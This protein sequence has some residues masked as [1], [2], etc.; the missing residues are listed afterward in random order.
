[1]HI[2]VKFALILVFGLLPVGT[3]TLRLLFKKTIVWRIALLVFNY[4]VISGFFAFT[5]GILG[6]KS[7]YW[8]V[9]VITL[10]LL[11]S[12][13]MIVHFVQKPI[14]HLTDGLVKLSAGNLKIKIDEGHLDRQDEVGDMSR[15]TMELSS[16]ISSIIKS[17][18]DCSNQVNDLSSLL[19]QESKGLTDQTNSQSGAAE[20]ISASMEEIAANIENN[21]D[22]A[23]KTSKIANSAFEQM[24]T[25]NKSMIETMSILT[26]ISDKIGI[27]SDIA[28]QTNI[29]ALNAAVESARAGE[30]GKG[31]AVV[32]A[33]V[34]KLAERSNEAA[35]EILNLAEQSS[36]LADKSGTEIEKVLPDIKQTSFMIDEITA[37]TMEQNSGA[38]QINQALISFSHNTQN[39]ARIAESLNSKASSL[40]EVASNLASQI[41]YFNMD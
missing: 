33:E 8:V 22:N 34:R 13:I 17:I 40:S 16:K 1:M 12:N 11:T 6:L 4:S 7:L 39:N 19:N 41:S 28:S 14:Q 23:K 5:V 9:P 21:T 32:A 37:A 10:I 29:L 26:V 31:F 25:T 38:Q 3:L 27:I 15:A 36:N 20:E 35:K 18:D 24:A 2:I 30:H